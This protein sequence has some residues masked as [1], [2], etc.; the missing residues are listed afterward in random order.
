MTIKA[1]AGNRWI[2]DR[3]AG[4]E[5]F[6]ATKMGAIEQRIIF[7]KMVGHSLDGMRY[8]AS[9]VAG[10]TPSDDDTLDFF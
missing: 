5:S 3:L 4:D 6:L 7:S 2:K 8:L 9:A 10:I 1:S